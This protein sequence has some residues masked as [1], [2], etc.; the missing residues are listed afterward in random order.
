[1]KDRSCFNIFG[2]SKFVIA[3]HF[4]FVGVTPFGVILN[5]SHII[6]FLANLHFCRLIAKLS[7]FSLCSILSISF[8]CLSNVPLVIIRISS[9]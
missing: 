7:S 9:K 4:C 5:P 3:S 8:S 6:S 1:M 2:F